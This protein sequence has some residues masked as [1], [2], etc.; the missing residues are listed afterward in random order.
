MKKPIDPE[1]LFH[2]VLQD[3]YELRRSQSSHEGNVWRPETDVYETE[4]E[5]VI[6]MAV[7]GVRTE[8]IDIQL[9]GN[10]FTIRGMRYARRD[11]QV[12]NYHQMEIR[13][14]YFERKIRIHKPFDPDGARANYKDGFLFLRVPKTLE[15]MPQ[16]IFAIRLK[17]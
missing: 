13:N 3:F 1:G 15:E 14:G 16:R 8:Q 10:V 2:R 6:K 12:V 11:D 17:L 4:K 9:N 7:P 5:I